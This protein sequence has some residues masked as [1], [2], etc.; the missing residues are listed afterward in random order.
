MTKR[1]R[2][3]TLVYVLL[4][5]VVLLVVL[6]VIKNRSQPRGEK[7]TTEKLELRTIKE[8]V[9]AS[10]KIFPVTEVKISSD[11][12]GEIVELYVEEGDS[13]VA[14][15]VLAKIDPDAFQSQVERAEATV[16]G[17]KAQLADARSTVE[18]FK[19]QKEQI[20]AQLLNAKEIHK[21]NEKLKEEGVV[22]QADYDGS[23]SN[24]RALEANLRSADANIRAAEQRAKA[25]EFSI[26]SSE[27]TLREIRTNLKRTTI[28]AP[29]SGIVSLLNVEK[30]ERV[31]G[32]IQMAGTELMRIANLNA[33]EVQVEVSENDIPRVSIG[34][35]VD[36]EVDAYIDRTFK[37]KVSQLANS[38][39]NTATSGITSL[40]TDQVTNFIVTIDMNPDSY[41]DL[42]SGK[43]PYPFRP[44]MSASVEINTE[45]LKDVL[46][47]PI[48]AV[49]TRELKEDELEEGDDEPIKEVVFVVSAD[50]VDMVVVETGIQDN[51]Y[52]RILKGLEEG[53]EVVTGPYTA[54][55]RKL[56]EGESIR[57][58]DE[59]DLFEGGSDDE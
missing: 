44:G 51:D 26:K 30:G 34:D 58:V 17:S 57:V 31:V 18:N 15:Q 19:A 12:S 5:I 59:E 9:S 3:N 49:S 27:A 20:E 53:M 32:T 8:T 56:K 47:A 54:V 55:A 4:A 39:S 41:K 48:Q 40:T 28:Y 2:K 23:L 10:G 45:T 21:R 1:K 13:V 6:M 35:L 7:V 22:S 52:I 16:N 43:S 36:I 25:A 38:A 46:A 24:L 33:M 14:N 37:G 11:V 42:V 50:T 29:V